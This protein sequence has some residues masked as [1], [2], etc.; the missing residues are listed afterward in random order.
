[1]VCND[2]KC[3]ALEYKSG[4]TLISWHRL[5]SVHSNCLNKVHTQTGSKTH[6]LYVKKCILYKTASVRLS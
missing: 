3:R 6:T 4:I 5:W 2:R 1:M